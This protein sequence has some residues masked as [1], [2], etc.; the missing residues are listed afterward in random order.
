MGP[1]VGAAFGP[2]AFL[3]ER[4]PG[5]EPGRRCRRMEGG[6]DG[7]PDSGRPVRRRP[8][9]PLRLPPTRLS[10]GGARGRRLGLGPAPLA[11]LGRRGAGVLGP[12]RE[13]GV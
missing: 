1:A 7:K 11:A 4:E 9:P 5:A 12:A 10:S 3:P 13:E 6:G 8:P 2:G